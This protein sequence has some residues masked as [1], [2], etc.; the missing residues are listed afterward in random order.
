[1]VSTTRERRRLGVAMNRTDSFDERS[2]AHPYQDAAVRRLRDLE[3]AGVFHEQGLGKTKIG[4]SIALHWLGE[5]VVDAILV[6]TKKIIIPTWL[7]EIRKHTRLVGVQ[8]GPSFGSAALSLTGP[9]RFFVTNYEQLPKLED[10]LRRWLKARAVGAILDESH[11]IKNPDGSVS[12][13]LYHLRT[14][15]VRRLIMTGTP[16]ANRPYDMWN[17]IRF[18]DGGKT[19]GVDYETAK[20]NFDLPKSRAESTRFTHRLEQLNARLG[21]FTSR[22]TKT[23]TDLGLP[24][25]NIHTWRADLEPR[26]A[27]LYADYAAEARVLVTQGGILSFDD[28]TPLLKRIGRLLECVANPNALDQ[29]YSEQPGKDPVLLE[30]VAREV[31]G[32]KAIVW[33]AYRANAERLQI[34]LGANRSVVVHGGVGTASRL[35]RLERFG[36]AL[37]GPQLLIATPA[38]CKEGLTL[39]QATHVIYYDRSLSLDDYEQSQ[40]RI[41]R[42][43]QTRT[44]HVHRIIAV[45]TVD[46]W[47]DVLLTVKKAAASLAQGDVAAAVDRTDWTSH[48]DIFLEILGRGT[49]S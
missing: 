30:V 40:D 8:L 27:L 43:S 35:R 22:E 2:V 12:T 34:V 14:D 49:S 31:H 23:S 29:S 20:R 11:A 18:L 44:C 36:R 46:E 48:R 10:L 38:S 5:S 42:I 33:T 9:S 45:G 32:D 15:F 7:Q 4:L 26:Q 1:M 47:V 3:Y 39:T 6:V 21:L 25:K 16:A 19:F 28:T 17:Q 37:S 13:L 41:H 24:P